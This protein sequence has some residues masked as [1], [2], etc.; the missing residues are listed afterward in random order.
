MGSSSLSLP[1]GSLG[2]SSLILPLALGSSS[3]LLSPGSLGNLSLILPLALWVVN[4]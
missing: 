2:I 1:P 4:L 3:L